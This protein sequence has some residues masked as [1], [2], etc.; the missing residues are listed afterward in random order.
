M[1]HVCDVRYNVYVNAVWSIKR[2]VADNSNN[3]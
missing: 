1:R 3:C 2:A